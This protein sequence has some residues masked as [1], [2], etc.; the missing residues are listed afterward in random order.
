MAEKAIE[1]VYFKWATPMVIALRRDCSPR[2]TVDFWKLNAVA[3]RDAHALPR[4]DE[5][6]DSLEDAAIF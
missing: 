6:F 4:M 1:P 2:F 5:C 3:V